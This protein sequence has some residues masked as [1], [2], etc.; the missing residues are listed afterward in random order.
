MSFQR[1]RRRSSADFSKNT[2]FL[3]PKYQD[4]LNKSFRSWGSRPLWLPL[5]QR[6]AGLISKHQPTSLGSLFVLYYLTNWHDMPSELRSQNMGLGSQ[7]TR[8]RRRQRKD[9][10]QSL[11]LIPLTSYYKQGIS[12]MK[13]VLHC[14]RSPLRTLKLKRG[15]LPLRQF[16]KANN[17]FSRHLPSA[18]KPLLS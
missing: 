2:E 17:G 8:T 3:S 1:I 11:L 6:I 5:W 14:P 9:L 15:A 10:N 12:R 13:M 16:N 4:E 18:R 7:I